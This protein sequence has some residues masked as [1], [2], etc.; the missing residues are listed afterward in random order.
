[1]ILT[2][3]ASYPGILESVIKHIESR[4]GLTVEYRTLPP[5]SSGTFD[6]CNLYLDPDQSEEAKLYS[7]CHIFGH[8][9][10]WNS[11]EKDREIGLYYGVVKIYSEDEIT[12]VKAY[13]QRAS[14]IALYML[15]EAG[16]TDLDLW[17]TNWFCSDFAW[18]EHLYRTKEKLPYGSTW[19]EVGESDCI[20]PVTPP[21]FTPQAFEIRA[22]FN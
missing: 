4:Y 9:V 22:A 2:P 8:C 16:F 7:L 6:G 19:I 21:K 17:I 12:I 14:Q 5:G 15:N 11:S 3:I 10:Q 13:E 1:M 18:L 20:K